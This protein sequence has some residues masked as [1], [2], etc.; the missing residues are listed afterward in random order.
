MGGEGYRGLLPCS[1]KEHGEQSD[2]RWLINRVIHH[3][4]L[5]VEAERLD[6]DDERRITYLPWKAGGLE[7]GST[8][9]SGEEGNNG[10]RLWRG[11]GGDPPST[12]GRPGGTVGERWVISGGIHYLP[13]GGGRAGRLAVGDRGAILILPRGAGGVG[14][15]HWRK[16]LVIPPVPPAPRGRW[17]ITRPS[18]PARILCYSC[19]PG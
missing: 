19:S 3:L 9:Y 10:S 15:S 5:A 14:N 16:I 1:L 11:G 17:E 6:A 13:R 2:K 18:L 4:P 7:V 12:P 8:I